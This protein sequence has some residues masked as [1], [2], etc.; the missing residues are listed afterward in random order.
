MI[1]RVSSLVGCAALGLGT[2]AGFAKEVERVEARSS[3]KVVDARCKELSLLRS[4][5]GAGLT[6]CTSSLL[7][8]EDEEMVGIGSARSGRS[9]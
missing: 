8:A 4:R 6:C 3:S 2:T 7:V 1:A 9:R 5:E